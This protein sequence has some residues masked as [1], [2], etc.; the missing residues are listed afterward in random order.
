MASS[1]QNPTA[2]GFPIAI[3]ALGGTVVGLIARQPTI[4][5][6]TGLALGCAIALA[7]W[8]RERGR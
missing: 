3:V 4:G 2:G 7:I 1:P 5:F 8:W 6:L